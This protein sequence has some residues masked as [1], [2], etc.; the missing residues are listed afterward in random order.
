MMRRIKIAQ[1]ITR[2]DWGGSPDI[3]RIMCAHLDPRNYDITL[4]T[5][6]TKYPTAKTS[7]FLKSFKGKV[8]E[9]PH[10]KREVNPFDDIPA[11]F[12]LYNL[13]R[14]ERFDI[15][16]THTT[17][18][19]ILGR[20]AARLARCRVTVHTPHGHIFYGYFS[21]AA[22]GAIVAAESFATLFTDKIIALTQLEKR[23]MIK[24]GV[25]RADKIEVIYQGL[26]LEKYA[27]A[28]PC[29]ALTRK[30]FNIEDDE[31]VVGMVGRLEPVKGADY[32]VEAAK[33]IS[34]AAPKVKFIMAGDGSLRE[35]LEARVKMSGLMP[36][37]IFAGWREDIPEI[38]SMLDVLVLP[39]LNEAVG[40]AALEAG[41]AGVP[42][43]ATNVGGIPEVVKDNETGILVGPGD[44]QALAEAINALL[45][46]PE[47]RREL[48]ERGKAWVRGRF[49]AA[50]M[51]HRI[52]ELYEELLN[53]VILDEQ[54]K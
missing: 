12:E 18:A 31:L 34:P 41:A 35:K 46:D 22:T 44:P 33:L 40:M 54:K 30:S 42:V 4:V 47:K 3:V 1:V 28:A 32:F 50:E 10:L 25:A 45:K 51:T 43:V 23:D 26:E 7:E 21:P 52:S 5:G 38:L 39:S 29:R 36:K 37:F 15:V 16:H 11:F 53:K 20:I 2:L 6:P 9:I 17:K 13:F 8:I 48:S 27:L 19:G 14:R 49:E 24:F